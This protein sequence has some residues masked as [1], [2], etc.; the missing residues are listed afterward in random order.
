VTQETDSLPWNQHF[1]VN[2]SDSKVEHYLS[3]ELQR[4]LNSQKTEGSTTSS[5]ESQ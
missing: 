4:N 2:E 5:A 3:M 1:A